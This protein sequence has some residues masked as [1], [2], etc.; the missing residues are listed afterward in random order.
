M[1]QRDL[2]DHN[3]TIVQFASIC[4]DTLRDFQKPSGVKC[5]LDEVVN[6]ILLLECQNKLVGCEGGMLPYPDSFLSLTH[7]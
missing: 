3:A 4:L 6:K 2:N 1:T 7:S 5:M